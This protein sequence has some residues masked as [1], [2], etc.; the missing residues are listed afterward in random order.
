MRTLYSG[1]GVNVMEWCL[2]GSS[3]GQK[4]PI[5]VENAQETT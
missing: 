3:V 4:S 5:K 2:G 1:A